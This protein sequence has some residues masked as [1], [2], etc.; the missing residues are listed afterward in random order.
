MNTIKS[1]RS[2]LPLSK[3]TRSIIESDKRAALKILK[4]SKYWKEIPLVVRSV[5]C[6]VTDKV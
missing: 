4:R 5:D 3:E 2:N 1:K 6:T